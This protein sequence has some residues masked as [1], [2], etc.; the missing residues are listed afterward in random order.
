MQITGKFLTKGI[1]MILPPSSLSIERTVLASMMQ[2][3]TAIT[4]Y[5]ADKLDSSDFYNSDNQTIFQCIKDMANS[6]V[7]P[8]DSVLVQDA[9]IGKPN[10]DEEKAMMC[11]VEIMGVDTV[12]SIERHCSILKEK[13]QQRK[14]LTLSYQIQRSVDGEDES[15]L[16]KDFIDSE[17][18]KM[19]S[20]VGEGTTHIK[21]SI[22]ET[23]DM[24][25]SNNDT[26]KPIYYGYEELDKL[27]GGIIPG[28]LVIVG[29]RPGH[30]KTAFALDVV[31]NAAR[32]GNGALVFSLEMKKP[33]L[34]SRYITNIGQV[35]NTKIR[36]RTLTPQDFPGI[37]KAL[38]EIEK[39]PIYLNSDN[40]NPYEIRSEARRMKRKH[41]GIKLIV[42]DYLQ[43]IEDP[44][45]FKGDP[46]LTTNEKSKV[47]RN[48]AKEMDVGIIALAQL[49]RKCEERPHPHKRPIL[50]DLKESGNIE[51]D[52]HQIIFLYLGHK[53]GEFVDDV[54]IKENEM[55]AI[56]AK[57]REGAP[58]T[59][60]IFFEGEYSS[61]SDTQQ[62]LMEQDI[63]TVDDFVMG[64]DN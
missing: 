19:E 23:M 46:R 64:I 9:I 26:Y 28:E 63:F 59:A 22:S 25:Q 57:I 36:H 10:M 62:R 2:A 27:T 51:Q 15:P 8:L 5:G 20:I 30:G 17:L 48:L 33:Q 11:I 37:E 41:P 29:A 42:V 40:L 54:A 47:L 38:T 60:K 4:E 24:I 56:A 35:S 18:L 21:E 61:F 7:A 39:L 43:L 45:G 49:N 50:S 58:G 14:L 55:E 44:K 32:Q 53:Y 1:K 6:G 13:A 52:A 34:V 3:D 12:S 31:L 16:I